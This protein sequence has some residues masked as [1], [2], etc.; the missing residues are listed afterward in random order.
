MYFNHIITDQALFQAL[1]DLICLTVDRT[2]KYPDRFHQC[3]LR[4]TVLYSLFKRKSG[5]RIFRL[6]FTVRNI[7]HKQLLCFFPG[8][9]LYK[10]LW[11]PQL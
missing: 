7:I 2:V 10:F 9:F 3:F 8:N 1:F 4:T 6:Y 11:K 5:F